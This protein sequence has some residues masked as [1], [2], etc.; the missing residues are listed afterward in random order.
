MNN[1]RQMTEKLIPKE[2]SN[3]QHLFLN[4]QYFPCSKYR[5]NQIPEELRHK[6]RTFIDK[7]IS[8]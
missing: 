3:I 8:C 7:Q 2:F 1:L 6:I 5:N 4:F